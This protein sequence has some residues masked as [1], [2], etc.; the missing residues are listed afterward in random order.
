M[1][2]HLKLDFKKPFQR[3]INWPS[4]KKAKYLIAIAVIA[5]VLISS[6]VILYE[7][8]PS[9]SQL[10]ANS[11]GNSTT[12]SPVPKSG[13]G[14]KVRVTNETTSV[15]DSLYKAPG[16]IA[17]AKVINK[18]IWLEVA[19]DAWAYFQPG[20]GVDAKTGLP[21]AS[22]QSFEAFTDWDLGA[23]IQAIIDA[24][25]IGL[26]TLADANTRFTTI[27]NF[28]KN[29]PINEATGYPFWFYDA[30]NGQDD[31]SMSEN[32]TFTADTADLGPLFV[33]LNNLR[34][35]ESAFNSTINNIVLNGTSN[36]AAL[37]PSIQADSTTRS[38]Y[39]YFI[40]TGFAD[41]WPQ[42]VGYV[43]GDVLTSILNAPTIS[44]DGVSLP[45]V[46]I[47]NEPLIRSVFE[48]SNVPSG[49][50][51]LMSKV[52]AADEALFDQTGKLVAPSEGQTPSDGWLYSWVIGPHGEPWEVTNSCPY[53]ACYYFPAF[54]YNKVAF[55]YLALYNTTFARNL[56]AFI[57]NTCPTPTNGYYDG[58]DAAGDV[59]NSVGVNTNSLILDAALYALQK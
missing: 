7:A 42:Q 14:S 25:K 39:S 53:T 19:T 22:G 2:P 52:Y 59:I 48:I 34:V 45:N 10:A 35:F 54:L 41:F 5:V 49:L 43:P 21:Y 20:V 27:L 13:A 55:S 11:Q 28:L 44:V 31:V 50:T 4:K 29:R 32:A 1:R 33:A 40:D 47:G 16:I 17:T 46:L 56:C 38:T 15:G 30:T 23:Y 37:L 26:E 57:E 36:F 8:G 58:A 18:T 12:G 24:Q 9:K 6:F 51:D 3:Q